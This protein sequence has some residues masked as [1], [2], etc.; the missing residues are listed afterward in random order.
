MSFRKEIKKLS[1]QIED[2]ED[3]LL[4]NIKNVEG[5]VVERRKFLIKLTWV[6]GIIAVLLILSNLYLRVRGVGF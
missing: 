1:N 2:V 3:N 6:V 5:W 4:G